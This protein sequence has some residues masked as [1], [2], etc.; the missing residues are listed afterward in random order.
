MEGISH[1]DDRLR[2]VCELIRQQAE[3]FLQ[4]LDQRSDG[5][6]ALSNI[7]DHDGKISES[8]RNKIVMSVY[9]ITNETTIST[10]NPAQPGRNGEFGIVSPPLYIDLHLIFL[11]N[12]VD[13]AYPNGLVAIS[14]IISFFQQTPAF[15][16]ATAPDLPPS[17]D[18]L[19]LE[20]TNLSPMDANYVLGMLGARYLPSVFYKLRMIPFASDAMSSRAYPARGASVDGNPEGGRGRR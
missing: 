7:V 11:A 15:T 6:T 2:T 18:K 3:M 12:F 10:Y 20:F 5:W 16:H 9:A 4:N 14:R 8:I 13:H 1:M 19:T 17:V